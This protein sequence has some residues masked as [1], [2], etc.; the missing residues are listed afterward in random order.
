MFLQKAIIEMMVHLRL[1]AVLELGHRG[2]ER[3]SGRG[4][5]GP[6]VVRSEE[7]GRPG[8]GPL[9]CAGHARAA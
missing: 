2:G 4:R 8:A 7:G 5:K 3:V 9:S 6:E 1:N